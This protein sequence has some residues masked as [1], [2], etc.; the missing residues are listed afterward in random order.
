[1]KVAKT[2]R[3][4]NGKQKNCFELFRKIIEELDRT[5]FTINEII[6]EFCSSSNIKI[7]NPEI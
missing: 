2:T 4:R 3:N 1:M 5:Q 6:E 7:L